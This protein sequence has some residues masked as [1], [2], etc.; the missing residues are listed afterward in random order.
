VNDLYHWVLN[1]KQTLLGDANLDFVVDGSDFGIWNSHKFT[2]TSAWT[3]GD[4]TADRAVDGSDFAIW[5]SNKFSSAVN[6]NGPNGFMENKLPAGG[7][8]AAIEQSEIIDAIWADP[9]SAGSIRYTV[10]PSQ[11]AMESSKPSASRPR[12]RILT[13]PAS[14][15]DILARIFHPPIGRIVYRD[16]L[17][18]E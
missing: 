18:A 4:F 13:R 9:R 14:S 11:S 7:S 5:N 1:L 3:K 2:T 8:R 15:S 17:E 10:P 6:R 16:G 12:P